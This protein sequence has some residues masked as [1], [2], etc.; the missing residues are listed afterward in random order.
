MVEPT[1]FTEIFID[2]QNVASNYASINA[3]CQQAF[4]CN[5]FNMDKIKK[6]SKILDTLTNS[7]NV[8]NTSLESIQNLFDNIDNEVV[9]YMHI[10]EKVKNE[11]LSLTNEPNEPNEPNEIKN[12]LDIKN[13]I[14]KITDYI[15]KF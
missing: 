11:L 13:E 14:E 3:S 4:Y 5:R 15:E 2:C 9:V 1:E 12:N 8:I 10:L 7:K 6:L